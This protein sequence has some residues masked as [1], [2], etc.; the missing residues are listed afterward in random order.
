MAKGYFCLQGQSELSLLRIC[1]TRMIMKAKIK[2][3]IIK[4]IVELLRENDIVME[5]PYD[6]ENFMN[7][8]THSDLFK[9]G[10]FDLDY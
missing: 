5:S 10:L 4:D 7:D 8:V 1:L 2:I 9:T 3:K 6:F